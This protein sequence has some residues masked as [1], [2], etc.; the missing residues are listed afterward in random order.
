MSKA[1]VS[2]WKI[3]MLIFVGFCGLYFCWLG[4]DRKLLVRSMK[5]GPMHKNIANSCSRALGSMQNYM[6]RHYPKP[7]TYSRGDCTCSPVRYFAILSM[8]RSGSGWFETL[9]NSHPNISSHGEVFSVKSRRANFSAISETLDM[10]YNLDWFSSASKN[11]CTAA[12]GFKWMLNQRDEIAEWDT[13]I[14]CAL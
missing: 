1:G 8:Q 4:V 9:L 3:L 12:V 10:V 11:E 7:K 5:R 13:Q 6:L 2:I 14:T